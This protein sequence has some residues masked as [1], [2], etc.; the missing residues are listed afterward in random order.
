MCK[1]NPDPNS[2]D[3]TYTRTNHVFGQNPERCLEQ[4]HDVIDPQSPVLDLGSGQGR[5]TFFL[6]RKGY[7]VHA[8]EPSGVACELLAKQ[9]EKETLN[10]RIFQCGFSDHAV[11]SASY[12]AILVY[13]LLQILSSGERAEL[14]SLLNRWLCPGG[15]VFITAFSVEDPSMPRFRSEWEETAENQFS[16]PRGESRFFL[17][18]GEIIELFA[19]YDVV[20]HWEGMGHWHH[21]GDHQLERHAMVEAVLRKVS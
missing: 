15:Y 10:I 7:E 12:S 2:Y 17:K 3:D 11:P 1:G 19:D 9:A 20:H 13:G 18:P 5:H 21:H 16:G 6:A 8:L 14:L 4:F